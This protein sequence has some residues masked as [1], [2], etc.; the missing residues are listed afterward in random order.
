MNETDSTPAERMSA[1]LTI[2]RAV[3]WLKTLPHAQLAYDPH[4][5][6]MYVVFDN[7]WYGEQY[8]DEVICADWREIVRFVQ[9]G[10]RDAGDLHI[11]GDSPTENPVPGKELQAAETLSWRV[12]VSH[13]PWEPGEGDTWFTPMSAEGMTHAINSGDLLWRALWDEI[14]LA[15]FDG[16]D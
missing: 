10:G 5:G 14:E 13:A 16:E 7:R 2:M 6:V 12:K 8:N 11:P 3:G 9:A 1:T 15:T 4:D